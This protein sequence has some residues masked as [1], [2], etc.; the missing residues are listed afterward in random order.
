[1]YFDR[2]NF[3]FISL[4]VLEIN[5]DTFCFKFS[6]CLVFYPKM[7][8]D[9]LPPNSKNKNT[10][11]VEDEKKEKKMSAFGQ[12]VQRKKPVFQPGNSANSFDNEV[13]GI[14]PRGP[15]KV[16]KAVWTSNSVTI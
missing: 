3:T 5:V 16:P 10:S 9:Y 13:A 8:A 7:D 11:K 14:F 4:F 6:N 2:F 1:M 15:S 12:A